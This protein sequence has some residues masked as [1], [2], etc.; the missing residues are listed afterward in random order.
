MRKGEG[1]SPVCENCVGLCRSL[2]VKRSGHNETS[3]T[4]MKLSLRN[5]CI[6]L[7]SKEERNL[8]LFKLLLFKRCYQRIL[9]SCLMIELFKVARI[10]A[11]VK[12][13]FFNCRTADVLK[14]HSR[15]PQDYL[16]R[17]FV[18]DIKKKE[19]ERRHLGVSEGTFYPIP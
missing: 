10:S 9:D 1:D 15:F 4:V 14:G 3:H 7:A 6:E 5:Q 11:W 8:V 16:P 2:N 19:K 12:S 18:H 17:C 13:L